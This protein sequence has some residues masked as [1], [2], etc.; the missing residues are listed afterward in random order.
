MSNKKIFSS[1]LSL[2]GNIYDSKYETK[3]LREHEQSL[4][5]PNTRLCLYYYFLQARLRMNKEISYRQRMDRV[6]EVIME[7]KS[8]TVIHHCRLMNHM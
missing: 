5:I 7:V 8:E 4:E 1:A 3:I 6:D 2:L